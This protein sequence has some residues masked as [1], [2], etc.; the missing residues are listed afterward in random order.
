MKRTS[1]ITR[2]SLAAALTAALTVVSPIGALAAG[3]PT[4]SV[5]Q[6]VSVTDASPAST[7]TTVTRTVTAATKHPTLRPGS[8]GKAV[9]TLQKQLNALGYWAGGKA[10]GEYGT[11]T[12]QAVMA[13]Q[14]VAGLPRSGVAGPK[15][16]KALAK[17]VRPKARSSQG[18]VIEIGKKRQVLKVV[19]NGKVAYTVNTSTGS[20]K[21]YTS[22]GSTHIASTPSGHYKVY[23]QING[24]RHAALGVLYRPKY[25]NG[26]IAVHGSNSVPAYAASHGCARVTDAVMDWLWGQGKMPIGTSVWVY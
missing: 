6:A 4:A 20:G 10:D 14:K 16:W 15:V 24:Y 18:H 7:T 3:Q 1:T 2:L 22:Q 9:R 5:T 23:R 26:G 17:G 19:N 21:K 8:S 12:Q 11:N 13:L 25:F